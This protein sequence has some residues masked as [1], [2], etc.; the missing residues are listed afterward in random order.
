LIFAESP[1]TSPHH[2]PSGQSVNNPFEY[3]QI[4]SYAFQVL[5]TWT[6]ILMHIKDKVDQGKKGQFIAMFFSTFNS[7]LAF[8]RIDPFTNHVNT[9]LTIISNAPGSISF[10]RNLPFTG[11][12]LLNNNASQIS[13]DKCNIILSLNGEFF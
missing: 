10:E 9:I 2:S 6:F 5:Y 12:I 8:S 13:L 7:L 11:S 4:I 3:I 1:K